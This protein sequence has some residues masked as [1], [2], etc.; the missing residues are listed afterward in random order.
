MGGIHHMQVILLNLPFPF[1]M[2]A[3][4]PSPVRVQ[5]ASQ[6]VWSLVGSMQ[7]L[8]LQPRTSW[9]P[10]RDFARL[11]RQ[12]NG[13]GEPPQMPTSRKSGRVEG[14]TATCFHESPSHRHVAT[15]AKSQRLCTVTKRIVKY[16]LYRARLWSF[17]N[18][19]Y[20]LQCHDVPLIYIYT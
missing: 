1:H 11:F 8:S 12:P 18:Y 10:C 20:D 2:S 19:V 9:A 5:D 4:A 16:R 6:V 17:Y 7:S 3:W 14:F 15:F 13:F